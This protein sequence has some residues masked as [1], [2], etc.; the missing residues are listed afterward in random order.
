MQFPKFQ[1]P[2]HLR[3]AALAP[4]LCLVK[5]HFLQSSAREA[6]DLGRAPQD[7]LLLHKQS[8]PDQPRWPAGCQHGLWAVGPDDPGRDHLLPRPARAATKIHT[9]LVPTMPPTTPCLAQLGANTS[10][11]GGRG[12]GPTGEPVSRPLGAPSF[13]RTNTTGTQRPREK[14]R[15]TGTPQGPREWAW[16]C[17][18][19][20]RRA[21]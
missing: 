3:A 2:E 16:L 7:P 14:S 1:A 11:T 18:V 6:G 10:P 12:P 4:L 8:Q 19:R 20:F 5:S 13:R 15:T 9:G 21:G 17:R